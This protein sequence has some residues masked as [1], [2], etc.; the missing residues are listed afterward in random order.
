M[1]DRDAPVTRPAPQPAAPAQATAKVPG[2]TGPAKGRESAAVKRYVQDTMDVLAYLRK[3]LEKADVEDVYQRIAAIALLEALTLFG[4]A[5]QHNP[6]WPHLHVP[7]PE[8]IATARGR[9]AGPGLRESL[10]AWM[11]ALA[12]PA[13]R[14]FWCRRAFRFNGLAIES[15]YH[16][17]LAHAEAAMVLLFDPALVDVQGDRIGLTPDG[18]DAAL[19]LRDNP[20]DLG[21][22]E[23]VRNLQVRE[24]F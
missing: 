24:F 8:L 23:D 12:Q 5:M 3:P 13:H 15:R 4:D 10:E 20:V 22:L 18:V 21:L 14:L 17:L 19:R 1:F 2:R 16:A 7:E 6:S 11:K 9:A